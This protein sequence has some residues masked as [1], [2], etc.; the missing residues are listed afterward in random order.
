M[1]ETFYG[2]FETRRQGSGGIWH[3]LNRFL[4]GAIILAI[5]FGGAIT[6]L[7]IIKQ[8][9]DENT[10]I[11]A[12][13]RDLAKEKALYERRKREVSLLQS[14]PEYVETIARDRLDMMKPGETILRIDAGK[15]PAPVATERKN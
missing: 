3:A 10:R 8:R 15:S 4:I 2:D 7:P 1:N 9:H 6:F 12:L 11:E 13:Q 5:C 14:D